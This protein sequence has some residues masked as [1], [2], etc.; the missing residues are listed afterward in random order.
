MSDIVLKK[1]SVEKLS[2]PDLNFPIG[3]IPSDEGRQMS[4]K[5]T[6]R[7][8]NEEILFIEVEEDFIDFVLSFLT[9]PLG[10]VLHILEGVSSISCIDNLYKSMSEL[11]PERYL[12]SKRIKDKL[13]KPKCF[14]QFEISN[15]ILPIA[16]SSLSGYFHLSNGII[17]HSTDITKEMISSKYNVN[18][19]FLLLPD[20]IP[21]KLVDPYT[22]SIAKTTF[23]RG[24]LMYMVTDDLCVTPMSSISTTSY[25]KRC[26]VS[27]S[28]L[29]ES[30]K[31]V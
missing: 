7:K 16:A 12:I 14:P 6:V 31:L 15:Q 10:G 8:S 20:F 17:A 4:V 2:N 3:G 21:F 29:E 11:S 1:Q 9:F 30:S 23:A 19:H 18:V 26:K 5:V 13:S 22:S 27:L 24:P 28:D 25:L